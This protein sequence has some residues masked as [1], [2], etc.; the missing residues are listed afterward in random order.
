LLPGIVDGST[1]ATRLTRAHV[2][3]C[4]RCQAELAQYRRLRRA[5]RSLAVDPP[6]G[7][8]DL[9]DAI[10]LRLDELPERASARAHRIVVYVGGAAATAAGAA[11]GALVLT[12]RARTS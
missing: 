7:P 1:V 9:L 11:L 8:P 2:G 10:L 12:R 5:S 3:R 6:P 4:L